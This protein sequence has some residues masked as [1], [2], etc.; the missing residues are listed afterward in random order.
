MSTE[1]SDEELLKDY[2]KEC[3]FYQLLNRILRGGKNPFELFYGKYFTKRLYF[4][5]KNFYHK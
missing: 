4:T 1:V 2:T 5:I 3:F